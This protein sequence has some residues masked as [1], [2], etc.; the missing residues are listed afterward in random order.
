MNSNVKMR[1]TFELCVRAW[2]SFCSFL[3]F[4]ENLNFTTP[5]LTFALFIKNMDKWKKSIYN[6]DFVKIEVLHLNCVFVHGV[7]PVVFWPMSEN[8]QYPRS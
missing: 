2:C 1:P 8:A 4:L 5:N 3:T 6:E 7:R